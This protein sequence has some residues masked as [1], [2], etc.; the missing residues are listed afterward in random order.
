MWRFLIVALIGLVIS[1]NSAFASG[2][3]ENAKLKSFKPLLIR[4]VVS[5]GPNLSKRMGFTEAES[6]F[7]KSKFSPET[8]KKIE[9]TAREFWSA[10]LL[11]AMASAGDAGSGRKIDPDDE[12]LSRYTER[13]IRLISDAQDQASYLPV[14]LVYLSQ[15]GFARIESS[16]E[17]TPASGRDLLGMVPVADFCERNPGS[18]VPVDFSVRFSPWDFGARLASTSRLHASLLDLV[19]RPDAFD[20]D[21]D[22]SVDEENDD[23]HESGQNAPDDEYEHGDLVG[24]Q[25]V[26]S[27]FEDKINSGT[28]KISELAA[29]TRRDQS[30]DQ[31]VRR[32]I[33]ATA[34]SVQGF[35]KSC[36][37]Q[38]GLWQELRWT[39]DRWLEFFSC[40]DKSG[41]QKGAVFAVEDGDLLTGDAIFSMSVDTFRF[42]A[43]LD[44][45]ESGLSVRYDTGSQGFSSQT[46]FYSSGAVRAVQD[47]SVSPNNRII[48]SANGQ[49]ESVTSLRA[50]KGFRSLSWYSTGMP[51]SFELLNDDGSVSAVG[52]YHPNGQV[53]YWLPVRSGRKDGRF[54]WWHASG[55]LAGDTEFVS[56]KRFGRG[57]VYYENGVEGFQGD[58]ADD[59]LHGRIIWRDPAGRPLFSLGFTSGRPHGQL[60]IR[61]GT[62]T[63]VEAK[64]DGGSVKG[65]VI[66]RNEL[67]L[68]VAEIPYEGGLLNGNVLL[69]DK[70]GMVRVRSGWLDGQLHGETEVT[71]ASGSKAANCKFDQGHLV[72]WASFRPDGGFRYSGTVT[73]LN[74]GRAIIS[75]FGGE[76]SPVLRCKTTDWQI[77]DCDAIVDGNFK[78]APILKDLLSKVSSAGGLKFK[79]EKC[80]GSLRAFDVSPFTDLPRGKVEISYRVKELC[81]S[82]N[83]A[84]GLQCHLDLNRGKWVITSCVYSD[85][86]LVQEE[87]E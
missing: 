80:G 61:Q 68:S 3:V 22:S 65:P 21:E 45:A 69:R 20:F 59:S 26:L 19:I 14:R 24:W 75:Y 46:W 48:F 81:S 42:E 27:R 33:L 12:W 36:E 25:A 72:N 5:P 57:S 66:L 9:A 77:T 71:Y 16:E 2:E 40:R 8:L 43:K 30:I 1:Y 54:Y 49:V 60:E 76:A 56:N 70:T 62:Q 78:P 10:S 31:S 32:L 67:G 23:R 41:F 86:D 18:E 83:L 4:P 58:Y 47:Y 29:Q 17:M 63:I 7:L 28:L 64:F 11:Q 35:K 87:S 73:T 39:T 85:D 52:G 6:I 13:Q 84:T 38:G 15:S 37:S 50:L 74:A 44:G 51:R 34:V 82:R 55:K 53:K 79:P